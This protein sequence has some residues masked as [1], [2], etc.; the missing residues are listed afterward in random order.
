MTVKKKEVGETSLKHYRAYIRLHSGILDN[1]GMAV[2]HALKTIGFDTVQD[3]RIGK[4]LTYRAKDL[5]EAEAVA[6]SQVNEVMENY[7][8][9]EIEDDS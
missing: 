2:T 8:V 9:K 6:K 1:A 4:V 3:V 7:V 5:E